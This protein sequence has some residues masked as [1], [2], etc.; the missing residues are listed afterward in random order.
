M[1]RSILIYTPNQL[2]RSLLTFPFAKNRMADAAV[3]AMIDQL[4]A[5]I[6]SAGIPNSCEDMEQTKGVIKTDCENPLAVWR[7]GG[8]SR[9]EWF[10]RREYV[11]YLSFHPVSPNTAY[12]MTFAEGAEV[13]IQTLQSIRLRVLISFPRGSGLSQSELVLDHFLRVHRD[14]GQ[15]GCLTPQRI[16]AQNPNGSSVS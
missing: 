9:I 13:C 1:C 7:T 16:Q 10:E 12:T 15:V 14:K 2:P 8:S 5:Q 6:E 3:T 11:L 4:T